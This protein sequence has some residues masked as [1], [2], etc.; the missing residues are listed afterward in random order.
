[1][2][3][4]HL[5]RFS[6]YPEKDYNIQEYRKLTNDERCNSWVWVSNIVCIAWAWVANIV[7]VSWVWVT[8]AICVTWD[9]V[10]TVVNAI[11]VTLESI[12]GWV[13]SA[14]GFVIEL[15][16][17][18]PILGAVLRWVWNCVSHIMFCIF[19]LFDAGLG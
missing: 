7:C 17:A 10:T 5:R 14:I 2:K 12:F 13:F 4:H 6:N 18:I 1:M 19:W 16:F 3:S 9:V 15:I 8:T 11:L